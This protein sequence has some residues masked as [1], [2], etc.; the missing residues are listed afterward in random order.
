MSSAMSAIGV[1]RTCSRHLRGCSAFLSAG[2]CNIANRGAL[3]IA[4]PAQIVELGP[5]MHGAAVIPHHQIVHAPAVAINEL[6]L[7]RMR[8]QL[9][10]EG[11]TFLLRQAE[12]AS[13]MGSE[14]ERLAAGFGNR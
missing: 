12:N 1:W 14:I 8:D 5:V 6:S 2:I 4:L 3:Q 11:T 13:R 9:I 10:D 7:G